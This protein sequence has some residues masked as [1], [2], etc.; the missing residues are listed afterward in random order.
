MKAYKFRLYPSAG[1]EKLLTN[2]LN[3]CR[4]LYNTFLQQRIYA[5]KMG[6]SIN[7]NYQQNQ[8]P[9]LKKAFPEFNNI[10][11][12]ILQDVAR[13]VDRA[14]DNFFRRIREKKNGKSIKAGFPRFKSKDRYS[15]I[16]YTQSGF[17]ILENGHV[18]LS[19]IG[20]VRMFMHRKLDGEIKTLTISRDSVGDWFASFSVYISPAMVHTDSGAHDQAG[21][22]IDLGITHLL[23][24]SNG[25]FV[26]APHFLTKAEKRLKRD[27]GR[28]S[29]KKKGSSNRDSQKRRVAKRHRKVKRQREDFI[30]KVSNHLVRNNRFLAF[31]N[32][33]IQGMVRNHHLAKSIIDASWNTLVQYTTYKA[34]SAGKVVVQVNPKGT[35]RTCSRCGWMKDNL[36]LSVRIFHCDDC[37]LVIDRDLNA[38]INIYKLGMTGIGRGTPEVTPVEIRAL[39]A[40]ATPV[41][42]AGSPR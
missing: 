20:G 26:D 13:R 34:G 41:A 9:D 31:E 36:K 18:W 22:G 32:L 11:S 25:T 27:Q 16:T 23:A 19:K 21:V 30:H 3:L 1:Q 7:Y 2:Q 12:Q 10:Y 17:R 29:R 33:D 39:P 37:G 38:A 5:H 28:L 40:M 4:E 42:E 24:L 15:S 14:Y 8:V 35:S 6:K